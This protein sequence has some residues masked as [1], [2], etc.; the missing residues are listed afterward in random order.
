MS[1][2]LFFYFKKIKVHGL[3]NIPKD[4]AVLFLANHQNALLDAL[5]IAT[6]SGRFSF[7]LTRAAVFQKPLVSKVLKSLQMMPVYRIRDGWNNISKNNAI[8][9]S[10]IGLFKNKEAVVIFPEGNHNLQRRV[11]PLSKGFTRIVFD[12]L[13][14]YPDIDIQLIPVGLN[15]I[16]S[17]DFFDSTAVFFGKPISARSFVT[18]DRNKDVV[19]IKAKIKAELSQLTTHI[20]EENYE[21][22]SSKLDVLQVDYLNP[23]AVN[24]CIN[25]KFKDCKNKPK[26]SISFLKSVFKFFMILNILIP[27]LIWTKNIKPKITE[28]EFRSTF[29]FAV[30]IVLVPF[31]L[32]LVTIGVA[33][34]TSTMIALLY[35]ISVLLIC[36]LA[37]KI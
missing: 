3:E 33:T 32:L 35:L 2:G 13:E 12:A 21:I 7:F 23:K 4:E 14:S 37:V 6:K 5:L 34:F 26:V 28:T 27:Y 30:A 8:F 24:T 10:C 18:E 31:Y 36:L 15:Y 1:L 29:R 11:R 16:S 17:P 22:I 25:S 20:P 19:T 9:K